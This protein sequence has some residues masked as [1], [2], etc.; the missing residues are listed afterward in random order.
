MRGVFID[1]IPDVWIHTDHSKSGLSSGYGVSVIAETTTGTLLSADSFFTAA[2]ES[3]PESVGKECALRLLD[4]TLF[5]GCVDSSF[6]PMALL[7]MALSS[8]K[9]VA[10]L[11]V[12]RVTKYSYFFNNVGL[13][14]CV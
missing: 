3:T 13:D 9:H 11:K 12:G 14:L 10:S 7:L 6:Q 5:G 8:N 1:Y 4:E 2:Q